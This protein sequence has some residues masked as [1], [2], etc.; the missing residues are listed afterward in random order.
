[1]R[2]RLVAIPSGLE[3]YPDFL[4]K[5]TLEKCVGHEFL[6]AGFNDLGMAELGIESVTGDMGETIW[7]EPEFLELV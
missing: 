5:S 7:V 3:D 2:V 4:T 1:M 6:V